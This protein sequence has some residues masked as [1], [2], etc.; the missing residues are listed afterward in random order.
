MALEKT[1]DIEGAIRVYEENIAGDKPY[2]AYH[3]FNR[4]MIL[5][6]KQKNYKDEMRVI[7]KAI[8]TFP[9]F[10]KYRDRLEKTKVLL[11]KL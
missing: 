1:G 10:V 6:R 4:L 2:P 11:S 9:D 3:S 7:E 5:Y 8:K